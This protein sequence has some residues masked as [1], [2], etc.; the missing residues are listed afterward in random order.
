MIFEKPPCS[1]YA[2]QKS[3]RDN[4]LRVQRLRGFCLYANVKADRFGLKR[5]RF[6]RVERPFRSRPFPP[7]KSKSR[8]AEFSHIHSLQNS[9][10]VIR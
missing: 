8:R 10:N 6:A 9:N 5:P 2:A 4:L 7:Q 1:A 3:F